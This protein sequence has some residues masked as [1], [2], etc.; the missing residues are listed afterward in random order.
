MIVAEH[1]VVGTLPRTGATFTVPGLLIL[2]VHDGLVTRV[3]DYMDGA[4]VRS[5]RG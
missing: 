5:A 2:H 1:V 3:R 4:G